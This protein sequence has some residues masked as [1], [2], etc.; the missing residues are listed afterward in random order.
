MRIYR[1]EKDG[2]VIWK[3]SGVVG[4]DDA[5][6]LSRTL[7]KDTNGTGGCWILDFEQVEH[8]NYRAFKVLEDWFPSNAHVLISGLSDYILDIFAIFRMTNTLR[9][10]PD[11]RTAFRYLM[12]ERGKILGSSPVSAIGQQ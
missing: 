2:I 9:V 6:T 5:R 4:L 7:H 1:T 11:W 12:A 8:V 3:L 10:F